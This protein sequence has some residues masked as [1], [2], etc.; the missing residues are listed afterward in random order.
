MKRQRA[1]FLDRD[2]TLIKEVGLLSRL[3]DIHIF[4]VS[5]AAVRK[6]NQSGALAIVITNQSAVARGLITEENLQELHNLIK[7]SFLENGAW[8]YAFYSC[9][10]HPEEGL[11]AYRRECECRKPKPGL[12]LKAAQEL[13]I[14]LGSSFLVGDRIRDIQAAHNAGCGAVLVQTG[15]GGG[16]VDSISTYLRDHPD[17]NVQTAQDVL[18][19]V[20]WILRQPCGFR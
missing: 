15:Y 7:L 6:I 9:P 16:E 11:A 17:R 3:S 5:Y 4:P 10:H 13:H 20:E 19:A 1:I 12:L 14:E 8:I 2:G 18:E